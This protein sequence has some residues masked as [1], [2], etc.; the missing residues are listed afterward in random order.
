MSSSVVR[1]FVT[2]LALLWLGAGAAGCTAQP[3]KTGEGQIT[4]VAETPVIAEFVQQVAGERATVH[5]LIPP[6]QD[7]H[8]YQLTAA[9]LR[10]L[11]EADLVLLNGGTLAPA[12]ERA[13]ES[14]VDPERVIVVSAG[15]EALATSEEHEKHEE[16]E[17]E[18]DHGGVDP[19][20]WLSVP[21]AIRYVEAIRDALTKVDPE[22]R[23]LYAQNAARL[24]EQLEELD[25]WIRQ[26]VAS[27][28][29]ERRLLVTG[30]QVFGYFAR[31]YGFTLVGTLIPSTSTEAEPSAE[32][33]RHLI[34]V[35]R[36]QQVPA[37]FVEQGI[38]PALAQQVAE[39]TGAKVVVGL[40]D[41]PDP[42]RPEIANYDAMMR[43][44]VMLIVEGLR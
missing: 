43:H 32:D 24:I 4:V 8:T 36:S 30:H 38:S 39:A 7:P 33:L 11:S 9:D 42:N 44:N 26:Q 22:G 14:Q 12:A 5:T 34:E 40:V 29:P 41:Q 2:L 19:H 1:Y 3:G 21:N 35:I 6:G 28:P 17:A 20:F 23:E 18:H 13:V 10:L 37:I 15:I 27:V 25:A 31:E 16:G